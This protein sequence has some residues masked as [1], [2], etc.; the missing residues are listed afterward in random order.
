LPF[1]LVADEDGQVARAYGVPS[2]LGM[3]ARVTFLVSPE[4]RIARVWPD[5]DPAIHADE[6]L[7][8]VEAMGSAPAVDAP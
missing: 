1:S 8:A 4:G 3:A 7:A 6:V 5:V 2:T